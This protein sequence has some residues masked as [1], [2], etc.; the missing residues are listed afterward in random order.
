[1][2]NL[3]YRN[4]VSIIVFFLLPWFYIENKTKL[5]I[6]DFNSNY[7]LILILIGVAYLLYLNIRYIKRLN[8][9]QKIV[10]I[11][12]MLVPILIV[13]Y[14]VLGMIAFSNYSVL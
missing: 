9:S 5:E 13:L 10:P 14:F 4:V 7:L 2:K 6:I 11:V 8:G 3:I 1:M 12:F